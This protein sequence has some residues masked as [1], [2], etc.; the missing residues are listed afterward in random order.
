MATQGPPF[1]T[2]S[3]IMIIPAAT[4]SARN[5]QVDDDADTAVLDLSTALYAG[6]WPSPA[7]HQPSNSALS[8]DSSADSTQQAHGAAASDGEG[9]DGYARPC[10]WRR[11]YVRRPELYCLVPETVLQNCGYRRVGW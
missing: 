5:Q 2:P 1:C 7:P 8:H 6:A 3:T 9:D 11:D 4:R 10:D